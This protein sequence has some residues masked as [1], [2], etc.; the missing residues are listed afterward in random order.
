MIQ[1]NVFF[2]ITARRW[3]LLFLNYTSCNIYFA[4]EVSDGKIFQIKFSTFCFLP[5]SLIRISHTYSI[6]SKKI[7]NLS[8][9]KCHNKLLRIRK[10]TLGRLSNDSRP[11]VRNEFR[12]SSNALLISTT[13]SAQCSSISFPILKFVTLFLRYKE[14]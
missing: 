5:K 14:P 4:M 13:D 6:Q 3:S 11:N 9:N 7:G 1:P 8:L 10:I 2:S 12:Q